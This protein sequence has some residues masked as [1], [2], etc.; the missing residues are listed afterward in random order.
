MSVTGDFGRGPKERTWELLRAGFVQF[1][2]SDAHRPDWRPPGLARA[3]AAIA[4]TLGDAV[5]RALTE[6]NPR[7]VVEDRPLPAERTTVAG[8]SGVS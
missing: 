3:R 6:D 1:V 8:V 2:A 5:A 4:A 7:A